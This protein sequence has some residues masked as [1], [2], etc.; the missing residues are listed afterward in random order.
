MFVYSS[1]SMFP[2]NEGIINWQLCYYENTANKGCVKRATFDHFSSFYARTITFL[3]H[4]IHEVVETCW[5]E[6]SLVLTTAV[7]ITSL[8]RAQLAKF[9]LQ[10][11]I[12][13][14]VNVSF[15]QLFLACF[16]IRGSQ[17]RRM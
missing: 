16:V 17:V 5:I 14:S 3:K 10:Y 7:S 12:L 4:E 9:V 11:C 6:C 2:H 1:S 8:N 13:L 15:N